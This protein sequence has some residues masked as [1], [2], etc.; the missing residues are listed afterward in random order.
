[1]GRE[2]LTYQ[3]DCDYKVPLYTRII[4]ESIDMHAKE[5]DH[6]GLKEYQLGL[7]NLDLMILTQW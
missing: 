3:G 5:A 2:V 7:A 6:E 4:V 1:M